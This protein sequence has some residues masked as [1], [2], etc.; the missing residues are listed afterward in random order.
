MNKKIR[1]N[2]R[3]R[4]KRR[5]FTNGGFNAF[6]WVK[7]AFGLAA[8]AF[9]S[10]FFIFCHDLITQSAV[11]RAEQVEVIGCKRLTETEILSRAQ[12]QPGENVLG[13]NLAQARKRLLAHP[14]I[15]EAE[16]SREIPS[17]I[18][19]RITEQ[20]PLAVI[21][22]G[23]KFLIN[24]AGIIF[25]EMDAHDPPDLPVVQ[26]L[27]FS[28]LYVP[29]PARAAVP[30]S[31]SAA[32]AGRRM[33]KPVFGSLYEAVMGALNLGLQNDG[34]NSN[35]TIKKIHVDRELGLTLVTAGSQT[36]IKLGFSAFSVKYELLKK[37]IDYLNQ[38]LV[39]KPQD[40][41]TIDLKNLNRI[42]L[43]PI[44]KGPNSDG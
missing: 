26:G 36:A 24:E 29:E 5:A 3:I 40:V 30:I 21:D 33:S 8:V 22:L 42:V 11:F 27:R 17:R 7:T 10:V 20:R 12:V 28:D 14:W 4:A 32:S 25:K 2:R 1:S 44:Q 15:A 38:G 31:E 9:M 19:I 18:L 34:V 6:H 37:I 43:N 41:D 39:L 16:L 13:V 35:W 23:R